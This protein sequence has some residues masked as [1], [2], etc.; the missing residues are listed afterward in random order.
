MLHTSIGYLCGNERIFHSAACLIFHLPRSILPR[1]IVC[2]LVCLLVSQTNS[3]MAPNPPPPAAAAPTAAAAPAAPSK[4]VAWRCSEAKQIMVQDMMDGIVPV[5]EKIKDPERLYRELYGDREEFADYPYTKNVPSRISRLQAT[6]G[7][8]GDA[9]TKD[10]AD[11]L[12]DR[13]RNPASSVGYNGRVLWKG[14]EADRMLKIDMAA[15]KHLRM[16]PREL[17][18]ERPLVYTEAFTVDRI[19]KRIDQLKEQKAKP[20]GATPGQIRSKASKK[21]AKQLPHGIKEKS[22]KG[23]I[24]PYNNNN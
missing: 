16:H 20:Y 13:A 2:R 15:G 8:M 11:F 9:A 7:K 12:V 4:K 3:I 19:A 17:K 5:K 21:K 22:R 1:I 6:V 24:D 23:T 14:S 18:A 10:N